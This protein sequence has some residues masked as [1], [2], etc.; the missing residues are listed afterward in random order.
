[1]A[2]T[3]LEEIEHRLLAN[4][5]FVDLWHTYINTNNTINIFGQIFIGKYVRVDHGFG[6]K[7]DGLENLVKSFALHALESGSPIQTA[8]GMDDDY[9]PILNIAIENFTNYII[10]SLFILVC[11]SKID[12]TIGDNESTWRARSTGTDFYPKNGRKNHVSVNLLTEIG[13]ARL[14]LDNYA[15]CPN[16]L[17]T[18]IYKS[19]II[20]EAKNH[21]FSVCVV[22][23]NDKYLRSRKRT[24]TIFELTGPVIKSIIADY[25]T[26]NYR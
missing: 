1:M 15:A 5:V 25:L 7:T 22:D 12:E 23:P 19:D 17:S 26:T 3:V 4:K 10:F 2:V 14:K 21:K 9:D 16:E 13:H 8:L 6:G 24:L 11:L 20:E 18:I